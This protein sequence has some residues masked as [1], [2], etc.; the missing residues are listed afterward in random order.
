MSQN[1]I[2]MGVFFSIPL[3]LQVVQGLDAFET[4]VKMLPVSITL[5]ATA[6][7]GSVLASRWSPRTIVRVG[8][9]VLLLACLALLGTI[10]A[11]IDDSSFSVAMAVLGIG[12]GLIASQIGNVVQSSVGESD[13]SEAGGLQY[14][15]QQLGASIGTA[16]I[17]AVVISGLVVAFQ[18][19]VSNDPRI[20]AE[21]EEQV[22]IALEGDVSFVTSQRVADAARQTGIA[23]PEED[24]L[25]EGYERSQLIALKTGLLIAA[26]LSL[27]SLAFTRHLP[28]TRLGGLDAAGAASAPGAT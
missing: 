9:I 15:A 7:L 20:S 5:F 22:G 2:L 21:V 10:D 27:F 14:T 16:L 28:A 11:V 6:M 25:V 12:M 23:P 26:L 19:N 4:G 13:R 1:L 18:A 3:Y 17:G 24:A 8:F